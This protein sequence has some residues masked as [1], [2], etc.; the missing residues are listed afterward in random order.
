[1]HHDVLLRRVGVEVEFDRCGVAERDGAETGRFG[2][3]LEVLDDFGRQ[4]DNLAEAFA[5][6]AA[7]TIENEDDVDDTAAAC[8]VET[9]T[10]LIFVL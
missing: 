6:D 8:E 4:I 9:I 1:M 3:H 7:G 5:T 2:R 10:E